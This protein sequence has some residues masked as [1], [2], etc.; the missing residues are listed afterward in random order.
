MLKAVE[1]Y[2]FFLGW[3]T[4]VV[5]GDVL[6]NTTSVGMH[7]AEGESPV[8]ADALTG[9]QLVFDAVYT[10]LQTQLLKVSARLTSSDFLL[11]FLADSWIPGAV[12]E[13]RFPCCLPMSKSLRP[14]LCCLPISVDICPI[15]SL[16]GTSLSY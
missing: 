7:P 14:P 16:L 5:G 10:P 11:K 9:Y 8:A 15:P 6:A 2:Q 4:G 1:C 13:S 3:A 12:K